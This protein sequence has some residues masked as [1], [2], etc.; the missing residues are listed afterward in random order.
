MKKMKIRNQEKAMSVDITWDAYTIQ[1]VNDFF[2][3]QIQSRYLSLSKIKI[4]S[5]LLLFLTVG[6]S[7]KMTVEFINSSVVE[8]S[9]SLTVDATKICSGTV[10]AGVTGTANCSVSGGG[11]VSIAEGLYVMSARR[12]IASFDWTTGS[13]DLLDLI[14]GN[15]NRSS[16]IF[17]LQALFDEPDMLAS[18]KAKYQLMPNPITD[19]DGRCGNDEPGCGANGA[20]GISKKHYLVRIVGR[21]DKECGTNAIVGV[22]ANISDRIND[23]VDKNEAKAFYSGVQY[24]QDG[25]GDWKLVTRLSTGEEVWQDQR[26]KLLWSDKAALTYNWFQAAGYSKATATSQ[27]E[28]FYDSAPNSTA[29]TMCNGSACQPI[30]PISVCAEVNGG[31]LIDQSGAFTNYQANPENA[32]KG[33]L[34]ASAGVIW[35]LPSKNDFHQAEVNGVRKVLP[36]MDYEFWSSSSNSKYRWTVWRFFG[37]NGLFSDGNSSGRYVA[38]SVRCVGFVESAGI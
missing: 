14:A 10:I 30:Q 25:E 37:E 31:E 19:S 2:S 28:T 13:G 23:C 18:F 6:C 9:G 32:F 17:I 15:N 33:N 35:K 7:K 8:K 12:D 38:L 11:A 29:G 26:T 36:N 3:F 4:F 22:N 1:L 34:M 16:D 20:E 21:P 5:F 27:V 24:G